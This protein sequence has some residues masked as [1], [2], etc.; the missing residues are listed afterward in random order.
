MRQHFIMSAQVMILV[1][2]S[3]IIW[4]FGE[5][6]LWFN[7]KNYCHGWGLVYDFEFHGLLFI[8]VISSF[9][10]GVWNSFLHSLHH[11]ITP[12]DFWNNYLSVLWWFRLSIFCYDWLETILSSLRAHLGLAWGYLE[13]PSL[14][15]QGS[16]SS[17]LEQ[18]WVLPQSYIWVHLWLAWDSLE[19]PLYGLEFLAVISRSMSWVWNWFCHS[20]H[21]YFTP[22]DFWKISWS[23]LWWSCLFVFL[24]D[25]HW[26]TLISLGATLGLPSGSLMTP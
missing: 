11:Y 25:W 7:S 19:D 18:P 21:Y 5:Y 3:F 20:F 16:L 4:K 12:V 14:L 10:P 13:G 17:T 15:H 24:Y 2:W 9:I 1:V 26:T 6:L 23:F 8:P 22:V